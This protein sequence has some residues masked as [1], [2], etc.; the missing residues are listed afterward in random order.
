VAFILTKKLAVFEP[1]A[2]V[3]L[4]AAPADAAPEVTARA[5]WVSSQPGGRGA[6]REF[7]EVV[8]RAR[9]QWDAIVAK[10]LD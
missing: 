2:Q 4:S 1:D 5:H 10:Q 8:L 9:N 7:S 3:G 6:V